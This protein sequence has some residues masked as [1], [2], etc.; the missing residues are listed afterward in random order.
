MSANVK[1]TVHDQQTSAFVQELTDFASAN[2]E[3]SGSDLADHLRARG[4]TAEVVFY[5]EP[6]FYAEAWEAPEVTE[7]NARLRDQASGI[8]GTLWFTGYAVKAE[9]L[10]LTTIPPFLFVSGAMGS[11][12]TWAISAPQNRSADV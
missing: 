5:H 12:C 10:D 7:Y 8:M 11:A 3:G 4:Y 9:H 6:V 2:P 1:P